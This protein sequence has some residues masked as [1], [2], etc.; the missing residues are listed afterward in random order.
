MMQKGW[1]KGYFY[2]LDTVIGVIVLHFATS[3]RYIYVI[4][5]NKDVARYS[6]VNVKRLKMSLFIASGTVAALAG[7]GNARCTQLVPPSNVA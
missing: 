1:K 4:G 6:G 7:M 5:N 2:T 3:G